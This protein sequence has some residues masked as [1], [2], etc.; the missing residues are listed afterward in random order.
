MENFETHKKL[1]TDGKTA[2]LV[3][4]A[5]FAVL[6][7]VCSWIT[8][9]AQI[10]FTLQTLAIFTAL[11][12]LGGKRGTIAIAVYILLGAAGLPVF[13][14]FQGGIGVLANATGGYILGFLL[15]G[16]AYWG[17]TAAFRKICRTRRSETVVQTAAMLLG[18]L[19][20]YAAGTA[21]FIMIYAKN[22]GGIGIGAALSLCVVPF[23]LPDLIKIAMALFITRFSSLSR[24]FGAD[25]VS[26]RQDR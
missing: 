17:I 16:L 7:A 18:N 8:I 20:C 15:T 4:I 2:D 10:P 22:S 11:G 14:N 19:V 5:F 1:K 3:R 12:I 23:I 13:S 6:I 24:R 21:H 9:P 26:R 25:R